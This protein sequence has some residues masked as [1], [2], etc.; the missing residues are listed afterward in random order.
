MS[1]T[2]KVVF[3]VISKLKDENKYKREGTFIGEIDKE[4]YDEIKN[5]H[6]YSGNGYRIYK[7]DLFHIQ[8]S[9]MNCKDVKIIITGSMDS[10]VKTDFRLERITLT[11]QAFINGDVVWTPPPQL[12]HES[13]NESLGVCEENIIMSMPITSSVKATVFVKFIH[14]ETLSHTYVYYI[15]KQLYN[16]ITSDKIVI[17]SKKPTICNIIHENGNDYG[18]TPVIISKIVTEKIVPTDPLMNY[19]FLKDII[20]TDKIFALIKNKDEELEEKGDKKMTRNVMNELKFGKV[21]NVNMSIYGPAF[22]T[23]EGNEISYDK[24]EKKWVDVTDMTI[25]NGLFCMPVSKDQI[26]ND[27]YILHNG[28]WVRVSEVG[29]SELLV[30]KIF[31]QELAFV[32]PTKNMF[33]FEFYTKLV[34]FEFNDEPSE[35]NP[36]GNMLP[37]LMMKDNIDTKEMMMLMMMQN[38]GG[39]PLM[40]FS[41]PMLM[42]MMMNDSDSNDMLPLML[43]MSQ[44]K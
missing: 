20:K 38:K 21:Y 14:D 25:N 18:K 43:M 33:G 19:T 26:K 1:E 44:N 27:D 7:A 28:K 29:K 15:D 8:L 2:F 24:K 9:S 4:L 32:L 36:F 23:A 41:N 16:K 31:E 34:Y 10:N 13:L 35:E 3:G 5:S 30:E 6:I 11:P 22:E 39:A 37:F 17:G 40:D 42:Y 12:S